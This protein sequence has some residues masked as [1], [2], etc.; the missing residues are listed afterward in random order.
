MNQEKDQQEKD[1]QSSADEGK[2]SGVRSDMSADKE[3]A[4]TKGVAS[5]P[6]KPFPD[7]DALTDPTTGKIRKDEQAG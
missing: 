2:E 3:G 1:R 5:D 4:S 6:G 7:A